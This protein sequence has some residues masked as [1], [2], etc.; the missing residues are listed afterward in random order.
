LS[1]EKVFCNPTVLHL[2]IFRGRSD[3]VIAALTAG[4]PIPSP[5]M[6]TTFLIAGELSCFDLFVGKHE[7]NEILI[8]TKSER[9]V[10]FFILID[11]LKI[12]KSK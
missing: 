1:E 6:K 10:I 9:Y 3:T 12:S 5:I 8:I 7:S 11:L 2:S 4:N